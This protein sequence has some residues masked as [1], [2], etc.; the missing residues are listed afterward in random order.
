VGPLKPSKVKF[1]TAVTAPLR[2]DTGYL[3]EN[4]HMKVPGWLAQEQIEFDTEAKCAS[5]PAPLATAAVVLCTL[6]F[7]TGV[8]LLAIGF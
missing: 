8:G 1:G 4:G 7:W 3:L 2:A 6:G 5:H